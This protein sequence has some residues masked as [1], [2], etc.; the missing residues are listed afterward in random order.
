[1][2]KTNIQTLPPHIQSRP[3]TSISAVILTGQKADKWPI[4]DEL[5][6]SSR[7]LLTHNT[8]ADPAI[9]RR[10]IRSLRLYTSNDSW[11]YCYG[12]WCWRIVPTLV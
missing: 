4:W 5:F 2:N 6:C 8:S 9:L 12:I 3:L 10:I 7:F 1:M 11:M